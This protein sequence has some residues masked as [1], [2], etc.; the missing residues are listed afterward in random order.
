[1]M[2]SKQVKIALRVRDLDRSA[3]LYLRVGFREI[4]NDE[5]PNLRY[6]T[7]GHTWLILLD[8][9]RHGYHTAEEERGVKAGPL[10]RGF[11]MAVPV[12]DLD[13][14][15]RLWRAEGLPVIAEPEDAGWARTFSGLD[16]DGYEVT[17]EQF[18]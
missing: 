3:A 12:P 15:H 4:P 1:M 6:L 7:H 13:E 2:G 5:Q 10:G 18:A 11:V 9:E 16:P 14:V 17:F 8:L